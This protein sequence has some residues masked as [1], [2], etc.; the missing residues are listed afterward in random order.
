[1]VNSFVAAVCFY[2]ISNPFFFFYVATFQVWRT[3]YTYTK[4][5]LPVVEGKALICCLQ[6]LFI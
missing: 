1:M 4:M 5:D 6:M 2:T 3:L